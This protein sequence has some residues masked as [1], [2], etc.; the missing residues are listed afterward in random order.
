MSKKADKKLRDIK[1]LQSL[2]GNTPM[3]TEESVHVTEK[4]SH[5]NN[6]SGH[7]NIAFK[8]ISAAA[9]A[10]VAHD[11]RGLA[12]IMLV[13]IALLLGVYWIVGH[14][15]FSTELIRIGRHLSGN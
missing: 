11:L 5:A 1:R 15:A 2:Y 8:P 10:Q 7:F 14:T 9:H 6:N 3:P 12:G 13:M 4:P